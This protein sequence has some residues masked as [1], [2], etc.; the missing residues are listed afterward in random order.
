MVGALNPLAEAF[1]W[2]SKPV[3]TIG[4]WSKVDIAVRKAYQ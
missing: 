2:G 1:V 4:G 3:R